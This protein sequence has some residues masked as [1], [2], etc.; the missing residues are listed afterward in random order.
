MEVT[1]MLRILIN[2]WTKYPEQIE[3][4]SA[5]YNAINKILKK[6]VFKM[7][8]S[9]FQRYLEA[10]FLIFLQKISVQRAKKLPKV[11]SGTI[12]HG[13]VI[14]IHNSSLMESF[15]IND[16][17]NPYIGHRYHVYYLYKFSCSKKLDV[18]FWK[19]RL[20]KS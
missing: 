8:N 10:L 11:P 9:L 13:A 14:F 7:Y 19:A 18:T 6:Y 15:F 16:I 5:T 2:H 12:T 4:V 17:S 3:L 20:A 1:S